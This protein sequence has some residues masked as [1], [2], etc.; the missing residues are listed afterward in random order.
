MRKVGQKNT[1]PFFWGLKRSVFYGGDYPEHQVTRVERYG[2]RIYFYSDVTDESV[3][4]LSAYLDAA[5][6]ENLN[7]T[8]IGGKS[9][10]TEPIF[11]EINSYGGD[12][13]AGISASNK[14][15]TMFCPVIT[16]VT[17]ICASAATL[18]YLSG[19]ERWMSKNSFLMIHQIQCDYGSNIGFEEMR[20]D[21]AN[22]EKLMEFLSSF[23]ISKTKITPKEWEEIKSKDMYL[24]VQQCKKWG[25]YDRLI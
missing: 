8:I 18:I 15:Q 6:N 5:Q 17:G 9:P 20:N 23:Y 21:M 16:W 4:K 7:K 25:M 14:I 10:N 11:V 12:I 22:A 3:M 24:T 19:R 2:N 1:D 13:F